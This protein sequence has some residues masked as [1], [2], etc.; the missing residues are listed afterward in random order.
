VRRLV[1]A[2]RWRAL[3]G[4]RRGVA[5]AARAVPM[6]LRVAALNRA[7]AIG[8]LDYDRA[9]I[10][11]RVESEVEYDTRLHS[12]EKEP[13]L[14]RWLGETFHGG[15]VFYDIG[16]NVGAYSLV[17]AACGGPR[18]RVYA[19]EPGA[20]TFSQLCRNIA[21]NGF[22]GVVTPLP[23]ALTDFTRLVTFN[24][25][26][27]E[28]GAA[29]HAIGEAVD[30]KGDEYRP[31]YRQ[32]VIGFRLDDIRRQFALPSPTHLKIDVDGGERALVDGSHDT[33]REQSLRWI[34][35]ELEE[36]S[37]EGEAIIGT[38]REAG[39]SVASADPCVRDAVSG[40]LARL[41][42]YLFSRGE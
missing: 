28:A 11:M 1:R 33:L 25:R 26:N 39:F 35:I 23:I 17:A 38:F 34:F 22:D 32:P 27:L 9:T 37:T 16:A 13:E 2:V 18:S 5:R 14:V 42:N 24:Y 36:G 6:S 12:C 31:A 15:D 3:E 41:K 4:L 19:F 21:V 29:L 7:P 40:R 20:T 30:W 8:R 10:L